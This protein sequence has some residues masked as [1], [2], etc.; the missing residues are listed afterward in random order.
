MNLGT[1]D[2]T[3]TMP[4]L[5][6]RYSAFISPLLLSLLMTSLVSAV[7]LLKSRGLGIETLTNWT[8]TW[9]ASWIVAFPVLL[10]A[11]PIVRRLTKLLVE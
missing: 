1:T 4:K 10:L 3:I 11:L 9:L 5:P 6:S 8:T 2:C 7:S